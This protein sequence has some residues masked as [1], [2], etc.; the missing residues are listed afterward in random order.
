M[1]RAEPRYSEI[2]L[3]YIDDKIAAPTERSVEIS[4]AA[5]TFEQ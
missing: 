4:I 3:A 5:D 2:G 1:I